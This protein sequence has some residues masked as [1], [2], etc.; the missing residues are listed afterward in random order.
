MRHST[1]NTSHLRK[2]EILDSKDV[3]T[4]EPWIK[5]SVQKVRL[6]DGQIV[7][8]YHRVEFPEYVV[9]FAETKSGEVVT[10]LLYKHGVGKTCLA[11]PSGLLDPGEQPIDAAKRELV[12]ETGYNSNNW[13]LLGSFV[14]NGNYGC[15]KAHLFLAR[16]ARQTSDPD[17]GDLEE[18]L[19]QTVSRESLMDS[20]ENGKIEL[21]G[22]AAA[23]ALATIALESESE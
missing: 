22:T 13:R 12:E 9:V 16:D 23:I 2:W 7:D 21:I 20:L 10:E 4:A 18:I 15:G 17:S 8:D 1:D 3:F 5:L 11:L 6:P 14:M 19:V